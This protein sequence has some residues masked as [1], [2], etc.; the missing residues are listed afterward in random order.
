MEELEKRAKTS[1]T[2]YTKGEG[3][4]QTHVSERLSCGGK[5]VLLKKNKNHTTTVTHTYFCTNPQ[6]DNKTHYKM[7][8]S[9]FIGYGFLQ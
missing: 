5:K 8:P 2:F 3:W 9:W 7:V 1:I 4:F 6:R